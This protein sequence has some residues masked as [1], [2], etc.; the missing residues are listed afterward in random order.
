MLAEGI[1]PGFAAALRANGPIDAFA[2]CAQGI[3]M[4]DDCHMRHQATTMLL[5]RE[6]LPAMAE[7]APESVLPT[8]RML[9]ANGHFAL[10]MT[11]AAARAALMGIQG[12]PHSSLVVF[13]SRNGTDAA[14]QL[15]GLP[16]RWFTAPPRWWATRSTAP[17]SPTRTRPR[18]S[19]TPR[20]WSAAA[21]ARRRARRARPWP[22]SWA[23]AWPTRWSGPARWATSASA[24]ASGCASRCSTARAPRSA[25]TPRLR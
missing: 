5:L 1:A 12:T 9:A 24:A 22:P 7:H 25:W 8:A 15:A 16:D 19:A 20:W 3:A 10:T 6:A 14:V 4:G 13:I 18:T 11:I 23:A 17:A 21:W 2:L